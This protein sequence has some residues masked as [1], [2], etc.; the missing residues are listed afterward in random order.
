MALKHRITINV[1]DPHGKTGTVLKGA[2]ARLRTLDLNY[3]V[4]RL[5]A[6]VRIQFL[7]SAG[8]FL[9]LKLFSLLSVC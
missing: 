8:C 2:D 6:S 9:F 7:F 1:T 4:W 5:V 3:S